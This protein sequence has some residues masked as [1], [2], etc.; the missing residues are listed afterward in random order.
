MGKADLSHSRPRKQRSVPHNRKLF[1]TLHM[2]KEENLP[3][4]S[5]VFLESQPSSRYLHHSRYWDQNTG[6][7]RQDHM[8]C[9]AEDKEIKAQSFNLRSGSV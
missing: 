9:T 3:P 2:E 4:D 7:D 8:T 1:Q 6:H 5:G